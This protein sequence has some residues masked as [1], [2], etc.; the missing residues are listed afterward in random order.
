MEPEVFR[1][2]LA[3]LSGMRQG[4]VASTD[5][6][7]TQ[8]GTPNMGVTVAAGQALILGSTNAPVQ[9]AYN[10]YNDAP[11]NLTV[12]ASDPTNPRIDVVCA[13][14]QDAY[15]AGGTNTGLLQVITGT[16]GATPA[17]PAIPA[18]SIALAHI[19]I[20][21]AEATV[22]NARINTVNAVEAYGFVPSRCVGLLGFATCTGGTAVGT[23]TPGTLVPGFA[24]TVNVPS[25]TRNIRIRAAISASNSAV[26]NTVLEV[27]RDG[28][29]IPASW[30]YG[31]SAIDSRVL[32]CDVIDSAPAAGVHQYG[33]Y[34]WSTAADTISFTNG[35][36]Q[37]TVED[38]GPV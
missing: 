10:L 17:I 28:V 37:M 2:V 18:S 29:A 19:W 12:A 4:I 20:V 27:F 22:L 14:I 24:I 8:Q 26:Q 38:V 1:Q 11:L 9:G 7:T 34:A 15:Y 36:G 13:S 6:A 5:F 35:R 33:V 21:A 30:S 23:A 3:L 32:T 25:A 16:P 31:P